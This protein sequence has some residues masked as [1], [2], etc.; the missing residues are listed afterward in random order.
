MDKFVDKLEV[1]R[2]IVDI[3]VDKLGIVYGVDGSVAH[4]VQKSNVCLF[5]K[6]PPL[7]DIIHIMTYSSY[8]YVH[9]K[10]FLFS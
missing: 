2:V 8:L 10:I 6:Y 5:W 7:Y 3:I 9:L 4:L 1:G